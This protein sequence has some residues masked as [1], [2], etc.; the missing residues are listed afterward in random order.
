MLSDAFKRPLEA[1]PVTMR[2]GNET[3]MSKD[4]KHPDGHPLRPLYWLANYLAQRGDP[5]RAGMIVT[6]G[7]Y[8]GIVDAPLDVP[9]TVVYGD[10]GS[11]SVTLTK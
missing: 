1:F 6:T 8:C 4:G 3:L 11:L 7:S 2:H 9:L 10:L 5:L